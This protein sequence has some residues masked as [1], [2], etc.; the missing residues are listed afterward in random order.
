MCAKLKLRSREIESEAV[1]VAL[2]G[3][4]LY[5]A[6]VIKPLKPTASLEGRDK[7]VLR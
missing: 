7:V 1:T 3:C 6:Q 5:T 2:Y 4:T